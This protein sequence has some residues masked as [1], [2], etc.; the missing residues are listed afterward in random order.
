MA[1]GTTIILQPLFIKHFAFIEHC[2]G[3][4]SLNPLQANH[5][6]PT[7]GLLSVRD[8][9]CNLSEMIRYSLMSN[10]AI[11][12]DCWVTCGNFGLLLQCDAAVILLF[13]HLITNLA[14]GA[15]IFNQVEKIL[16]V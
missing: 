10:A 2:Q 8:S 16:V 3:R 5:F 14:K 4:W 9:K 1:T 6:R 13:R 12:G 15:K 11:L 7:I